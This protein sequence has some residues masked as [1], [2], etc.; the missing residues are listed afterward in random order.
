M[1]QDWFDNLGAPTQ[2][3]SRGPVYGA[4]PKTP[5]APSVY[6]QGRNAET[7]AR[8]ARDQAL[9][10]DKARRDSIEWNATHN[11]DGT[12]KP[13]AQPLTSD[14]RVELEKGATSINNLANGIASLRDQYTKN[15]KGKGIGSVAEY[16]P[17]I[18]RPENG[19]FNDTSGSLSA[20]VAAALGLSGQQFNTPAEQQL[21][22]GSIL[23][24]ASDTDEQ[25]QS[26]LDRLD[27]LLQNAR[28]TSDKLLGAQSV[29]G[30]ASPPTGT[31]PPPTQPPAGAP[32]GPT[33][34]PPSLG[35]TPGVDRSTSLT[36][37]PINGNDPQS[38]GVDAGGFRR[39][40]D[41]ALAG[42]QGEY[43]KRLGGGQST[44]ELVKFL[45][46]ARGSSLPAATIQTINQQV[47]YRKRHPDVP[48]SNYPVGQIDDQFIPQSAAR[49]IANAAADSSVGNAI[50]NSA[51]AATGFN[52]DSL[53]GNP[54]LTRLGLDEANQRHPVA[55]TL[56]TVGGGALAALGA[57][58]S[59]ARAGM[60]GG[61]IL[62]ARA[63][64]ADAAYGGVAG[65]GATDYGPDGA[66]ATAQD[67]LAGAG[68]G[69]LAGL[70]GNIAGRVT[71]AGLSSLARGVTNPATRAM[72]D[73]GAVR[74][75]GQQYG[76]SGR[77]GA[78][79][80]SVED[81][82]SG[83]PVVGDMV[84]ARR[85]E[86]FAKFNSGA[87]NR[88]LEP[89]GETVGSQVGEEA[90]QEAA[91]KVQQAFSKALAGKTVAPDPTFNAGL[92]GSLSKASAV[93][94]VGGE[95][96]DSIAHILEP[97]M[98]P[99]TATLSGEAMQEISR[100]LRKLKA[101]YK[102]DPLSHRI[103]QAIDGT[104]DAVF[105]LFKRQAPEVI[106]AYNNAKQAYRRVSILA[107]AVNKAV[108]REDK[109][110]TPAQLGTSN[111]ANAVKYGGRISA[112]AGDSPFNDYAAAGQSVLPNAVPDSGT[113]GRWL[114]PLALTGGGA[115]VG[116][117]SGDT[118]AGTTAG[119]TL[120]AI[121]TGAYSRA[122]QRL[123]T[124]PGRGMSG[125]VGKAIQSDAANTGLKAVGASSA[126]AA[127]PQQ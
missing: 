60:Q 58:A 97:Y 88:A 113:A 82:L 1:A 127:L 14:K 51:N 37:I 95:L 107:D 111:R 102:S 119:L 32:A 75:V 23:P 2:A 78:M 43:L 48:I 65:A 6:D 66:P 87:F 54:E 31:P 83:I 101:G 29:P 121:L 98:A 109:I 120:A 42:L 38:A 52:L 115:G 122:G 114:V 100:S 28:A 27:V 15:F 13:T 85:A 16:L 84:N 8:A 45:M 86:S 80:K 110:F 56:G 106:P 11:P 5:Q 19:V 73:V 125:P 35:P 61:G 25:I 3:A 22:I 81:R 7:D 50:V 10:E 59:L 112:A 62:G 55:S 39:E 72:Q 30:A 108:N 21:F 105:G 49:S 18:V 12:L 118:G 123:L 89:I 94:R 34:T 69:T 26:K 46:E 63:L 67:R 79:V 24:R 96:M 71:G 53:S 77:L 90:V 91:G 74:T 41:P 36:D 92:T 33:G 47:Q 99:G 126:I 117:A 17:P 44:G 104:E 70:A 64:A 4:P 103:G 57:E 76:Q 93:P 9:Q 20:Y 124:K 116:Y 68:K 40:N